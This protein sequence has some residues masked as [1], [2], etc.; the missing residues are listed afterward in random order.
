MPVL[1]EWLARL[2]S[3]AIT[4]IAILLTIIVG[5]FAFTDLPSKLGIVNGIGTY[6]RTFY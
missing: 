2:S 5:A 6:I 1:K 4:V 3:I